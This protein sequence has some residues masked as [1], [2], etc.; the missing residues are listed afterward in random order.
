MRA[1]EKF[2][3]QHGEIMEVV[4][5][6]RSH[7]VRDKITA[8]ATEVSRL[9]ARFM[10]KLNVHLAMEDK[11]LYPKL[12]SHDDAHVQS[13]TQKFITEMGGIAD[14]VGDYKARWS[15]AR[16]MQAEPDEFIAQTRRLFSALEKRVKSENT[17]LY[18]ALDDLEAKGS[19]RRPARA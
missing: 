17:I 8:D 16:V 18:K 2:R 12:L 3:V 9:L 6:I 11:N 10:G 19:A 5:E 15:S 7:L 4:T 14:A 1:T 13:M